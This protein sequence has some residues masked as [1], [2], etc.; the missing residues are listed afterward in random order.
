VKSGKAESY[1]GFFI[2]LL[3]SII[4]AGILMKQSH[5]DVG[6]FAVA[7]SKD[8]SPLQTTDPDNSTSDLQ[9]Y[10]PA[11]MMLLT[12]VEIFGSDSLSEKIDGKAEL[13]LSAGFLSLR[14]QRFAESGKPDTWLEV[15]VYDMGSMRNAFSVF[16][17]QRRAD[18][19]DVDFTQFAYRTT[20]ALF[21][22]QGQYY[23]EVIAASDQMAERMLAIAQNFVRENPFT[24]ESE[25]LG[26]AA[27]FPK[28]SLVPGSIA[29]LAENVFGFSNLDNTFVAH[30]TVLDNE[31]T[32]F[33]SRRQT[34][35][36][37]K[38]LALAYHQFLVE[39]GG[40][41]ASM[42]VAIPDA[43]LVKI[44][45]TFELIFV[46]GNF[47][48]GVHEAENKDLAEQLASD[49]NNALIGTER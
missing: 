13:Y 5:Y 33:L 47:L 2:L 41:D 16:S 26:E 15:F 23:V 20:N 49:L 42:N 43:R 14:C 6:M 12:P 46:H 10:L 28:T 22:L 7:L 45:D 32:A 21:F 29:L 39:N 24:T 11:G 37:A 31:L 3:L 8:A 36:E 35:Q 19:Q 30:Y 44:F 27:L 17:T 34:A 4:A 9:G 25:A 40:A 48:A 38:A 1:I 18:A